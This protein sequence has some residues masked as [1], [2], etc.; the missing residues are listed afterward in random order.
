VRT[1]HGT[2]NGTLTLAA[3]ARQ[4]Q[5]MVGNHVLVA[6]WCDPSIDLGRTTP[7][8][9]FGYTWPLDSDLLVDEV[10]FYAGRAVW[11]AVRTTNG[12]RYVFIE[13]VG[14][15]ETGDARE[16][17]VVFTPARLH[18]FQR[19][20]AVRTG[21]GQVLLREWYIGDEMLGYTISEV[22]KP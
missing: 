2:L 4:A 13:E 3:A 22:R 1:K 7:P 8:T 15:N 5:S 16:A 12:V 10:A 17:R 6:W 14:A 11:R 18:D 21:R 19:F 20:S 9:I